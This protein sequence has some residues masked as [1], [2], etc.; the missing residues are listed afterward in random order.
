MDV[1]GAAV[2]VAENALV[3]GWMAP[4]VVVLWQ[5][6]NGDRRDETR[7]ADPLHGD[8]N[9]AA[10]NDHGEDA[11]AAQ[12]RK[13]AAQFTMTHHRL[14]ANERH[15]QRLKPV[16]KAEHTANQIVAPLI[17]K[18][19]ERHRAAQVFRSIG[20]AAG[21]AQRTLAGDFNGKQWSMA[22][23]NLTPR[24]KDV[25]YSQAGAPGKKRMSCFQCT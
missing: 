22:E 4:H 17:R 13:N 24:F 19:A 3:R 23:E 2:Q 6:I 20:I 16:D 9:D 15:M 11:T 5:T 18:L 14:A 7:E 21:A 1:H 12:L 25:R 10:G 8:G